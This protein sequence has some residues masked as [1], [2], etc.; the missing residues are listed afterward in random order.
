MKRRVVAALAAVFAVGLVA[1]LIVRDRD[2][3]GA[4]G[5]LDGLQVV[6]ILL[7]QVAYLITESLRMQVVIER[8]AGVSLGPLDW[9][10]IFAVGRVINLLIPQGG[11]AYRAIALRETAGVPFTDF[12]GGIVAFL[13]LSVTLNLVVASALIAWKPTPSTSTAALG[14]WQ[15]ML[16]AALV[17]GVAPLLLNLVLRWINSDVALIRGVRRVVETAVAAVRDVGLLVRFFVVWLATLA[18]VLVMYRLVLDAVGADLGPGEIVALYTLVQVTAAVVLTPGNF[19]VQE[20]GFTGI[21][22]LFG[23]PAAQ[24]AAAAAIIR[25]T[26]L[27]VLLALGLASG[28]TDIRTYVGTRRTP[29]P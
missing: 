15:A 22:V 1:W 14:S 20:L 12:G 21:A 18:V 13:W 9:F 24:G 3:L 29:Q 23:V 25:I 11:N 19:G 2:A 26:G 5:D 7:L 10:R 27:V 17:V 28:L 16:G 4:L 6:W 8:A